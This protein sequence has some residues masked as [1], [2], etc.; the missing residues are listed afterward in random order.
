MTN[1]I[2]M[3]KRRYFTE[4]ARAAAAESRR[5]KR[6]NPAPKG[7]AEVFAVRLP[8]TGKTFGWEIR[9]FGSLILGR[10]VDQFGTAA[11]ARTAGEAA[12]SRDT[13]RNVV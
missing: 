8:P 9:R 13:A 7:M 2:P 3:A 1:P 10:G 5:L 11:E 12:M 4:V 6:E